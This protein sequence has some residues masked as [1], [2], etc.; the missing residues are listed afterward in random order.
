M[1]H[2]LILEAPISRWDEAIPLGN[3][4]L[5][6]LLWGEDSVVRMSLDRGDL[7]DERASAT[8]GGAEWNYR[9]IQRTVREGDLAGH[10][11]VGDEPY[12]QPYPTKIPAGRI[13]LMLPRK[14]KPERFELDLRSAT[15][16]AELTKGNIDVFCSAAEPVVVIRC[17]AVVPRLKIVAPAF[18]GVEGQTFSKKG[19]GDLGLLGYP[20]PQASREGGFDVY[21]QTCAEGLEFAIVA[22]MRKVDDGCEIAIA[23]T[24]N[25]EGDPVDE[26]KR[27]VAAALDAGYGRMHREHRKWWQEFWARSSIAIPDARLEQHYHLV[28]YFYGS[29]SRRGSPPIPLQGVWTADEGKLPPWKGDYHNDLNTQF[30]YYAY[31]AADHLEEGL[32]FLDFLWKLLP[33]HQQFA[34]EFYEVE[35]AA[36]PGVMS[37]AGREMGGWGQYSFSPTNGAWVAHLFHLHWRYTMDREFLEQRAYPYC[38]EVARFLEGLLKP[39]ADGKLKLP[40]SSSPEIH[41]NRLEAYVTPNSNYDLALMRWLFGAVGEMAG[42]LGKTEEAGHWG[43]VLSNLDELAVGV[44]GREKDVLLVA[45]GEALAESHRHFSHLMAIHPLGILNIEAGER[46]RKIIAASLNQIDRLGTGEWCGYSFSWMAGMAAR[47]GCAGRALEM[48]KLYLDGFVSR[49]GFHLNGDYK[50]LGL[51]AHKYRPFTL[52]G[53]FAAAEAVQEM[54]VQSWGGR[55]RIFPAVVEEWEEASFEDLRAEGAFRVSARREAGR[56]VWVGIRAERGG[57]L[58]LRDPFEGGKVRWKGKKPRREG[59]DYV[60]DLAA[61]GVI[62]GRI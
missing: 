21:R 17:R 2:K 46:E 12:F 33:R 9:T 28:Q 60:I 53:N 47:A 13:E 6:C 19:W 24:T 50:E 36:V 8:V 32:C 39:G 52:E 30:C 31:P 14:A 23:V 45:P 34:R 56:T 57:R 20:A 38:R 37:L 61:G 7:W 62:E 51:S 29:A 5:G 49:N 11:R 41:D 44:E 4:L 40:L 22:G 48:L 42:M 59:G 35:G 54:L 26:G 55:V 18:A 10:S 25:A 27:R 43:A 15:G 16:K 58:V 1:K 3:G